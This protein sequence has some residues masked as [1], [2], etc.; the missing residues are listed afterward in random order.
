MLPKSFQ[1]I[2]DSTA[3]VEEDS[4]TRVYPSYTYK[5]DWENGSVLGMTDGIEAIRQAIYKMLF[6]D[7]YSEIIYDKNYGN[8][9]YTLRG[10]EI[11]YAELL[12]PTYIKDSLMQD[13]RIKSVEDI[14][15]TRIDSDTLQVTLTVKTIYGDLVET[16]EVGI[17]G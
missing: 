13:D 17:G 8:D 6:T 7:R 1:Y 9:L 3:E 14:E 4:S 16:K 11:D 10:Q 5:I 2:Q 15:V 12:T